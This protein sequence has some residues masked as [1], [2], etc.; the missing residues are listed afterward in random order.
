MEDNRVECPN[1]WGVIHWLFTSVAKNM[2]LGLRKQIQLV[3]R[4][5][6][7]RGALQLQV[8]CSYYLATCTA[9]LQ[10][11]WVSLRSCPSDGPEM[12]ELCHHWWQEWEKNKALPVISFLIKKVR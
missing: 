10:K 12:K 9:S 6:L 3:V 8:Q 5:G 2:N 11:K 4:V 1:Q 7:E